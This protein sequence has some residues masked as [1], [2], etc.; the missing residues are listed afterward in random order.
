M[1]AEASIHVS[2]RQ[3]EKRQASPAGRPSWPG[4]HCVPCQSTADGDG[5]EDGTECRRLRGGSSHQAGDMNLCWNEIK[6]KS[7]NIR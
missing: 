2:S 1:T 5:Q 3:T 4:C 7:H 6:R